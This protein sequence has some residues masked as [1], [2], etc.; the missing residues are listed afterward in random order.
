[1]LSDMTIHTKGYPN[2]GTDLGPRS[3]AGR[4]GA[5][6]ASGSFILSS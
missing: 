2:G 6:F 5:G 4:V 3:R 1:M